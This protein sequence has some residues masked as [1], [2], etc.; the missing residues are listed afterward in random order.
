MHALHIYS[1]VIMKRA[2]SFLK[3]NLFLH[4]F[5]HLLDISIHS[6]DTHHSSLWVPPSSVLSSWLKFSCFL[7]RR[8]KQLSV[9]LNQ[10]I[11]DI[12]CPKGLHFL[13]KF[14]VLVEQCHVVQRTEGWSKVWT[15]APWLRQFCSQ[16]SIGYCLW[17]IH[18]NKEH[19]IHDIYSHRIIEWCG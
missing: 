19:K 5:Y 16:G 17:Q 11:F 2:G 12:L 3:F 6:V 14:V 13:L 18:T 10:C 4:C 9:S 7:S 8:R 15:L 1:Q